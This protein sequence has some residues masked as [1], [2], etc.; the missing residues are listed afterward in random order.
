[1]LTL[2]TLGLAYAFNVS[3]V[4]IMHVRLIRKH[5]APAWTHFT[6]L[7]VAVV[8]LEL[9]LLL[10]IGHL[11]AATTVAFVKAEAQDGYTAAR[12][13]AGRAVAGRASELGFKHGGEVEQLLVDIG[14][15]VAAGTL[16]AKLDSANAEAQLQQ[17]K[18]D[19]SLAAA[20]LAALEAETQ[21]ARQTEARFL[22]LRQA[23]HA[24]AQVYDEQRLALRA[25]EAQLNVA[26]ANLLRAEAARNAASIIVDEA[27]IY[28]PF[29]GTV[30]ARHLDEGSQVGAG[31]NVL[32]LVEVDHTEA[33]VGIPE[34]LAAR[35]DAEA[36][37]RVIWEGMA[38][39]ARLKAVLPEVDPT[40][41]TLTAVFDLETSEIPL[42]AVV[43]LELTS[44]IPEPGYWLPLTALTESDR[45]LWGVFVINAESVIERRLV[46]IIHAEADRAYVRGTLTPGERVVRTG[47]QRIV[48]GQKVSPST[49]VAARP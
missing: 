45:G 16:L 12:V 31:Q 13:Y 42:G 9:L 30:Q 18:A 28:A 27:H 35:L 3:N 44:H 15:V 10:G 43:E 49:A 2:L 7:A 41:R 8:I 40:T 6:R 26:R 32:R 1:M 25:K 33:H 38:Y 17:A 37:N 29:A 48:P 11:Q 22:K 5:L 21:L 19:V 20:N 46:E 14:D 24:S 34:A 23:G 39:P 4:H 47:V 36:D